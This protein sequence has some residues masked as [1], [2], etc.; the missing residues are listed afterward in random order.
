MFSAFAPNSMVSSGARC[1]HSDH[2]PCACV[3]V[4]VCVRVRVCMTTMCVCVWCVYDNRVCVCVCGWHRWDNTNIQTGDITGTIQ[5]AIPTVD[6][7]AS[8]GLPILHY[9]KTGNITGNL[10]GDIPW[11]TSYTGISLPSMKA[12]KAT[13]PA[14]IPLPQDATI[15]L[16]RS[17]P[18][19]SNSGKEDKFED[20]MAQMSTSI[21]VCQLNPIYTLL[22][23]RK[24]LKEVETIY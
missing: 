16:L 6:W 10:R 4:C 15:G 5:G 1:T 13:I 17:T 11:L 24:Q 3:C 7:G 22:V 21:V 20:K 18:A 2:E 14:V 12:P 9:K 8:L 23:Y 19:F